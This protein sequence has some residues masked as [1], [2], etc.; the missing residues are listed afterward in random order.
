MFDTAIENMACILLK[1]ENFGYHDGTQRTIIHKMAVMKHEN[2]SCGE[3]SMALPRNLGTM[4]VP[5]NIWG[6]KCEN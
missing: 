4:M 3:D 2:P 6:G 1:Y 5:K